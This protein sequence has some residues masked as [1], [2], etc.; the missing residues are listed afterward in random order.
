MLITLHVNRQVS[1]RCCRIITNIT[2]VRF[3]AASIR[4]ASRQTR[5]LLTGQTIAT[6][7]LAV[8]ML[9][10]HMNFQSLL[11]FV[12]P[13][14]LR[15]FERFAWVTRWD[16]N[17]GIESSRV[18][19][20]FTSDTIKKN[21]QSIILFVEFASINKKLTVSNQRQM[22]GHLHARDMHRW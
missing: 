8:R 9:F 22:V 13:I 19:N 5:M 2:T 17:A 11:I 4:F 7:T 6:C 21:I 1:L 3:V 16:L 18:Q 14:A 12:V 10:A 15:T 20:Q